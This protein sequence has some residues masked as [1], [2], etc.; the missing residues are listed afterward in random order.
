[1]VNKVTPDTMLSASRL[2]SVMGISRYQTPNDELEYSIRALRGEDRP[3]IGNESMNWGNQLEAPGRL[4]QDDWLQ[5]VAPL[6]GFV[7]IELDL[8]AL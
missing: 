7:G 6:H 2:P 5:G 8:N 1:M 4:A 3:D